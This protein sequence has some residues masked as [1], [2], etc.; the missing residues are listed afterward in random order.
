MLNRIKRRCK[1]SVPNNVL[2]DTFV[3]IL[4]LS[5]WVT[6]LEIKLSAFTFMSLHDL[7]HTILNVLE[8]FP[9]SNNAVDVRVTMRQP[10]IHFS[11]LLND[12]VN[13]IIEFAHHVL[14]NRGFTGHDRHRSNTGTPS[15]R[16]MCSCRVSRELQS[17]GTSASNKRSGPRSAISPCKSFAGGLITLRPRFKRQTRAPVVELQGDRLNIVRTNGN[18]FQT[19][20]ER[21]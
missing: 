18:W 21:Q 7:S 11:L 14:A 9:C 13:C 15:T 3:K 12:Q 5:S 8:I 19:D 1:R 17:M 16:Q 10:S 20:Q 2:L 6:T 4:K